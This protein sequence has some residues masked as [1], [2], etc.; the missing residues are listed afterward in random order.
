MKEN[1]F[2]YNTLINSLVF[3]LNIKNDLNIYCAF[4][5]N[6]RDIFLY[7][8]QRIGIYLE[9][10]NSKGIFDS[11]V[12]NNIH[13]IANYLYE[14]F[15][16][17]TNE[18]NDSDKLLLNDFLN[19]IKKHLNVCLDSNCDYVREQI[20]MRNYGVK[21]KLNPHWRGLKQISDDIID[22]FKNEYYTSI[23]KDILFINLLNEPRD[24]FYNSDYKNFT[25]DKD[26][27]RS[28]NY[29]WLTSPEFR[30]NHKYYGRIKFMISSNLEM[31]TDLFMSGDFDDEEFADIHNASLRL[32]KVK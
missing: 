11:K 5:N 14:K 2:Y 17:L 6:N 12:K 15:P 4:F 16:Y 19:A 3:S 9:K 23:S 13:E 32:L 7:M 26:F 28:I 24:N 10:C 31:L 22:T 18:K 27:Y 20:L 30:S 25:L 29:F 1:E 8:V 21:N